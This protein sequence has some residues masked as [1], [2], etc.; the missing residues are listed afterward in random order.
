MPVNG[1]G[2]EMSERTKDRLLAIGQA[3]G[4]MITLVF[5]WGIFVLAKM[6]FE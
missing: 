3:I 4:G 2:K 5:V 6:A 1:K